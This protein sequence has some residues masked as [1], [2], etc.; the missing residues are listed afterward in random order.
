MPPVLFSAPLKAMGKAD[1]WER[2]GGSLV[3]DPGKLMGAGWQP[4]GDTKTGL[5]RLAAASR[6]AR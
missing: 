1:V 3:V 4:Q 2:L 6:A 5:E